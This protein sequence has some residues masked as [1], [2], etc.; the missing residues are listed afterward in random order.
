MGNRLWLAAAG[1]ALWAPGDGFAQDGETIL[2]ARCASCHERT[3]D[4]LERIK[5]QRKTA[6]GWD[7]TIVRMMQLA[8]R[9]DHA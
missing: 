7:M 6:E 1:I 8:R 9:R 3:D 4:G 5:E 2:N